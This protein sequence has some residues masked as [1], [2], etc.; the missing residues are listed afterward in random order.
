MVNTPAAAPHGRSFEEMC[1]AVG[2]CPTSFKRLQCISLVLSLDHSLQHPV[3]Y[4][5]PVL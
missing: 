1:T 3:G 5:Q 4:W 2:G